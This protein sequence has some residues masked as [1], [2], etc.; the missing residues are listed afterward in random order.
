MFK[1]LILLALYC[2][3]PKIINNT[4]FP[5]NSYDQKTLDHAKIRCKELYSNSPCLITFT[6]TAEKDYRVICGR[7]R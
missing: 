4:S 5:W 2:P 1:S 6:K 3:I 7:L